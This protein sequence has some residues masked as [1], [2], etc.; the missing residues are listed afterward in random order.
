MRKPPLIQQLDDLRAQVDAARGIMRT[1]HAALRVG[2][3]TSEQG[4]EGDCRRRARA[5]IEAFPGVY[6]VTGAQVCEYTRIVSTRQHG[7]ATYAVRGYAVCVDCFHALRDVERDARAEAE[8]ELDA[9]A[10]AE[11]SLRQSIARAIAAADARSVARERDAARLDWLDEMRDGDVIF[12]TT[13]LDCVAE[14]RWRDGLTPRAAQGNNVRDAI[15]AARA[16]RLPAEA[17]QKPAENVNAAGGEC[18]S[19]QSAPELPRIHGGDRG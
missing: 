19:L 2:G 9:G 11:D 6:P 14:V 10:A 3:P 1:A 8:R 5:A 7:P 13:H 16:A 17:F 18:S 15:D 12:R 4:Y